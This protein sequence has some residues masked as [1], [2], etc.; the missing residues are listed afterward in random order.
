MHRLDEYNT[1]VGAATSIITMASPSPEACRW[2]PFKPVCP[3]FWATVTPEW[4][5]Q[6]DGEVIRGRI[7]APPQPLTTPGAYSLVV[8]VEG[9]TIEAAS[10]ARLAPLSVDIHSSLSTLTT[11]DR[12]ILTRL[13]KRS[14]GRLFPMLQTLLIP[15][16]ELVGI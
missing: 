3:A 13:G 4:S 2:C 11:G 15:L 12:I 5:G 6:L 14:D 10:S 9:G 7:S 1:A 8:N 16:K